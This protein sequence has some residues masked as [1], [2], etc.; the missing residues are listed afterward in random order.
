MD[1]ISVLFRPENLTVIGLVIGGSFI[2]YTVLHMIASKSKTKPISREEIERKKFIERMKVNVNQSSSRFLYRG[3]TLIGRIEC[4]RTFITKGNPHDYLIAEMVIQPSLKLPLIHID[5][6]LS[7]EQA[8]QI[9]IGEYGE[10]ENFKGVIKPNCIEDKDK[11]I[12]PEWISFNY[13]FGIYYDITIA[14]EHQDI[15]LAKDLAL[16]DLMNEKSVDFCKAQEMATIG[17]MPYAHEMGMEEKRKQTEIEKRK[18][19]Q[20]TI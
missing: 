16:T 2:V 9:N 20:Q 11:L 3:K 8:F 7:K 19:E 5:N 10:S 18:G 15:I 13:Y 17:Y 14:R 6:P 4:F 12:V 1:I